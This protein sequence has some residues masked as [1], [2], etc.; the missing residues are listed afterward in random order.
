MTRDSNMP[1]RG[2]HRALFGFLA[3]VALIVF[4]LG[5]IL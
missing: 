1:P 3:A 5:Q 4:S 2:L